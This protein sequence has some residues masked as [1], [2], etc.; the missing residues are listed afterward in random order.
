MQ[1]TGFRSRLLPHDVQQRLA[2]YPRAYA[3]ACFVRDHVGE[4][5]RLETIAERT[6]MA[7]CAF[8]RYF[9]EKIGIT[10]SSLVKVLRV[11]HAVTDLE[12]RERALSALAERSGF[13]SYCTFTR[14]FRE[15]MGETPSSY[16]QRF[17]YGLPRRVA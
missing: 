4:A 11:E 1:Q 9:S 12:Q 7:P 13:R 6:G 15:V 14:A 5:I 16:R 8:S 2:Y 10:F 3:T 17:L